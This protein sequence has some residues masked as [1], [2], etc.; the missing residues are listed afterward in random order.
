MDDVIRGYWA[1]AKFNGDFFCVETWSG[2]RSGSELDYKGKQ[3]L[4]TPDASEE[5]L[6]IAVLD[7]LA[8]SRFV[9]PAS[10]AG[11]IYPPDIEFDMDLHDYKLKI[12][13]HAQW[14]Q[15]LMAL[16]GYKTKRALFKDMHSC[17]IDKYNDIL[18]IR[19]SHHK[20]L[21]TWGREK[22]DGIEDVI[23][24]ATS[25]PREIGA[26]LRLAFSRCTG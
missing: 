4:L 21:E 25:T 20:K 9:L 18:T 19:P 24:P 3:H 2:Y 10:R 23:I 17:H 1:G 5:A 11:S 8:Y 16:Y 14:I 26:A 6:G 22:D 13:R 7:T 12:E 15:S